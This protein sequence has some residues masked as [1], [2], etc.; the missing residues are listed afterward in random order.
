MEFVST[1]AAYTPGT[2]PT[3]G[4]DWTDTTVTCRPQERTLFG[5]NTGY[6]YSP[7]TKLYER[8]CRYV[9]S[10]G[11]N[12]DPNG[13]YDIVDTVNAE[14]EVTK[15]SGTAP[16]FIFG[17]S[18]F[19]TTCLINCRTNFIFTV[20]G[21]TPCDITWTYFDTRYSSGRWSLK[22]CIVSNAG[23]GSNRQL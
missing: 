3:N 12:T 2:T 18:P 13:L 23:L 10:I 14:F 20:D 19:P 15:N 21:G 8:S 7:G 9:D 22:S 4:N 1:A 5:S 6:G 16:Y 11:L 17:L